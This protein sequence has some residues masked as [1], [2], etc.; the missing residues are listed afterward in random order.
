MPLSSDIK[1]QK[2][3]ALAAS[4]S[5]AFEAEAAELA[6]R[7][8]MATYKIDPTDIPDRSLYS[9]IS[10]TDNVLLKKLRDEWR[11]AHPVAAPAPKEESKRTGLE[12]LQEIPFNINGFSKVAY[13]KQ[14]GRKQARKL[15]RGNHEAIRLLLNQGLELKDIATRTGIPA[16]TLNSTRAYHKRKGKWVCDDKGHF[17][18]AKQS[19]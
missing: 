12:G 3:L 7:R 13:K 6:A 17:Q 14:S 15:S 16:T 4:A 1:F 18:W 5:N 2:A 10:F 19:S 8:L 11:T 9:R